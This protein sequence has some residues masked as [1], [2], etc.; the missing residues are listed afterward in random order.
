LSLILALVFAGETAGNSGDGVPFT[1]AN[2]GSS[3]RHGEG[4]TCGIPVPKGFVRSTENL[5]LYLND[6]SLLP[7]QFQ[8]ADTY[9]DGS[10]RWVLVDFEATIPGGQ[11]ASYRLG[12]RSGVPPASA[13]L[14]YSLADGVAT[15]DTG[16]A[17]FR[18]DTQRFRLLD[19][20]K[21]G[22]VEL[23]GEA[24]GDT[25]IVLEDVAGRRW[26]AADR[27]ARAEWEDAGP[28]RTVLCVRGQFG[29]EPT[30]PAD[31]VCRLHFRA[32]KAEVRVLLTVRNPSAHQHEGNLWD[33]GAR[34]STHIEDLS[35]LLPLAGGQPWRGAVPND[36]Q[37]A[38][39]TAIKLYQDSS[40]GENWRSVN[41]ID[42]D[43]RVPV[44]FRG[45]QI[46]ADGR[47]AG[48]GNRAAGWLHAVGSPGGAAVALREFWQN[49]PKALELS[50]PGLRIGLWPREFAVPHELQGG[51]QKTHEMLFVFHAPGMDA[52]A[53]E[54]RL[55]AFHQPLYAAP[56][57][58][59]VLAAGT[60]WPTAPLD[61]RRYARLEAACDANV[62]PA[63]P[64]GA[65]IQ[66]QWER[67]DE[68]G[69]RHFGDT[70]ADNERAP[71][72]M[73]RDFPEHHIGRM[74]ISHF[75]NEYDGIATLMLQGLRRE[76]PRWL[77]MA[78][79][80]AR[81]HAD[82]CI[83]HTDTG[84]PA[85]AHGPFMHTT[86]ETAAYRSTLRSYPVEAKRYNLR[87]GQGGGPN[88]GHTYVECLAHHYRLTGDRT[89]LEAFLEVAD[90]AADSPWFSR[91]MMGDQRGYGNLLATFVQAYQLS[92]NRKYY[93]RAM[94]LVGWIEEPFEGLGGTLLA[95]AAGGFLDM[96]AEAG[97]LDADYRRMQEL[98][99][100]IG[101]LYLELPESRWERSLEQRSFHSVVLAT[102]YLH[103][104][105][106]HPRRQAYY[107]RSRQILDA[108][109]DQFPDRYQPVKTWVM[110]F[111]NTG[112]YLKAGQSGGEGK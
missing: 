18:V 61:R 6:G 80:M 63:A 97:E 95:K 58:A 19:T 70:F 10:P 93:D 2:P 31:Y 9:A 32:G 53:I 51:E 109:L 112:A 38:G 111:A 34:G 67:I 36:A 54:D 56:D 30:P 26:S 60:F 59:A 22:G 79:V 14:S 86:H 85:Y 5:A 55:R 3:A 73:I 45:Y 40:G 84:S 99:L 52:Q 103:A 39:G 89:S 64:Q 82:I 20:V 37:T 98:L 69:W 65:T 15:I 43:Y 77:W 8:A 1:V 96:K 76:D 48:E 11:R 106:D 88:A 28:L 71:E 25:G 21:L 83:Y 13:K 17:V 57:P 29:A 81:H 66:S 7:A 50:Q 74:P 110:C 42:K 33:L 72:A 101:D 107:E 90:W 100:A 62:V 16:A 87:Y 49:F 92:R 94:T 91:R 102:C 46:E 108:A 75:V 47:R 12:R 78:D 44:S 27:P 4:L 105:A 24:T 23:L 35:I 68:Y 41:H 104:P